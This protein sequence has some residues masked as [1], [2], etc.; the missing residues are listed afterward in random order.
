MPKRW[1]IASYDSA[2]VT[3]LGRAAGVP[4]VVAQLLI[5][6]GICDVDGARQFLDVKLSGLRD[7][8]ELP[9]ATRSAELLHQAIRAGRR[10]TVYGDYDADGMTATSILLL[11]L[12]LLGAKA[13]FYIPSRLE[14]G[15]G[16]NHDALRTIAGQGGDVVV[17][18]DCGI[19][20]IAEAQ[21]ARELGL[22][23]II[24]DH[25][26]G[27]ETLPQAAA[28][29]HPGLPNSTYPFAG[30]CGAAVALKLA[31]A[32][33]QQASESKRVGEAMRTFLM[34]AVGLAAIG[35]VADVVP[36]VDENRILVRHG[37][38]CLRHYPT[39]GLLA[40]EKVTGLA[41]NP[42]ID[43]E[44][45]GFTIAP[46]LNAAGRLGQAPLAVELLT[47]DNPERALK[48]AE[49]I[50][51]LNDQRQTLERSVY[52]AAHKQAEEF[53]AAKN[54]PALVLAGRGWH[55]GV[56]GI[57]AGRLAE[58]YHK[59]TVLISLDELG[60]KPGMGSGRSVAR[61]NLHAALAVCGQHL[62]AHGGHEAAAGLTIHEANVEPFRQAFC[63]HVEQ[64]ISH[65]DRI[66]ELFVD[67]ETPLAALTHQTVRQIE[68]LAPFGRGNERPML[69]TTDVR[70]AEPPRRI[71]ATGRH[72]ALRFEQ[73]GVALRAV[74]FGGGDWEN[75]LNGASGPLAVAFK[76]IINNFRGKQTVEMQLTDWR[77]A[78]VE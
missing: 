26:R 58:Q 59:P 75:D 12:R 17:T 78:G 24:T 27:V 7:P 14:E 4:D 49:F 63:E 60:T 37:L 28:I 11:C 73:H 50:H 43:C 42:T 53:C 36:L 35:T 18:V 68:S 67:A 52:R 34:R 74:A 66:A 45:V 32:L 23:L 61:F 19:T 1:R 41:K 55:A 56:I 13:D 8:D 3:A 2:R 51:G 44:H 38:N 62:V 31:W 71:G 5:S 54:A 10:I 6:R 20:S 22:T 29:V 48:L 64:A 65:E 40:L 25:H 77:A 30:L 16:L 9:G 57:V 46:R 39:P 69:C 15:Y 21:T 47:T 76:P 72:L 70:L 33:C